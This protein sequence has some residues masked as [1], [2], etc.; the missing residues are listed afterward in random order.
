MRKYLA[1][2][3]QMDSQEN[4]EENLKIA[5]NLIL[6]AAAKGAKLA[7]L[8]ETMNYIGKGY[9]DQAEPVPGPTAQFLCGKA[10][11]GGIWVAGGSFPERTG[12][13]PKNTMLL[14]NPEGRIV[15]SY[16]KIHMFDVDIEGGVSYRESDTNTAGDRIVLAD[17]E[18]G[19]L[20]FAICYDIRF[21]E[22]FRLMA[23][24]GAQ[25]ICVPASFTLESGKDHWETLLRARAIENGVYILASNQIG[26][27]V[28]MNTYGNSM[29][30]DPWGTVIARAGERT[31]CIFAEID[32]DYLDSVRRQIP[33]LENRRQDVYQMTS[34]KISEY[35]Q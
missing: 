6:E 8:P 10:R 26:K 21:G 7:V 12:E 2:V 22:L 9:R 34:S 4:K 19:K 24:C 25:V 31:G 35:R 5:G 17:T 15:Q 13:N 27:K 28:T 11:E 23:L 3:C 1:A 16:S 30:I 32:L 20:G 14:I 33:V 29:I 18:L